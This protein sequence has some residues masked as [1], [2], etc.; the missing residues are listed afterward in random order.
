MVEVLDEPTA[1]SGASGDKLRAI[2]HRICHAKLE[3]ILIRGGSEV[4]GTKDH[5][6]EGFANQPGGMLVDGQ[7]ARSEDD[8]VCRARD[9]WHDPNQDNTGRV[10]N[11]Q[12]FSDSIPGDMGVEE[13]VVGGMEVERH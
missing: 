10:G 9:E 13:G 5:S 2:S 4:D 11:N 3:K 7:F 8:S 12:A 1:G 6:K